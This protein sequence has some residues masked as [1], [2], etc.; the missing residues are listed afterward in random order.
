[1]L[2]IT[3]DGRNM[4][5]EQSA[6]L[7]FKKKL[8]FPDYYGENISALIDCLTEPF[9]E[10]LHI[11][12]HNFRA[13]HEAIPEYA[14][15]FVGAFYDAAE[16]YQHVRLYKLTILDGAMEDLRDLIP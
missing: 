6:H 16:R 15:A 11:V 4:T 12:W 2:I 1:M 14:V 7:E 8:D 9:G 10:E 3:L 5:D 13:V